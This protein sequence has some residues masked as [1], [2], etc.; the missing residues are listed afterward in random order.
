[1]H[2]FRSQIPKDC[3]TAGH[4]LTSVR[5]TSYQTGCGCACTTQ[6]GSSAFGA[7]YCP[8]SCRGPPRRSGLATLWSAHLFQAATPRVTFEEGFHASDEA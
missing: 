5:V 6:P 8:T 2:R 1:M 4:G 3:G 7:A